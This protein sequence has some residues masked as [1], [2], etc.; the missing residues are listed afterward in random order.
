M[1]QNHLHPR[2]LK[3]QGRTPKLSGPRDQEVSP[4]AKKGGAWQAKAMASTTGGVQSGRP[5][6]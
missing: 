4:E 3:C 2:K 1:E 5:T 6:F